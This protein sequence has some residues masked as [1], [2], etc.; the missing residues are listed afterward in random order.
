MI[1]TTTLG[2]F[3][4]CG[5]SWLFA[6]FGFGLC[7]RLGGVVVLLN[8]IVLLGQLGRSGSRRSLGATTAF[9]L[10]GCG[11]LFGSFFLCCFRC[12]GSCPLLGTCLLFGGGKFGWDNVFF[13]LTTRRGLGWYLVDFWSLDAFLVFT[14]LSCL[15]GY[16]R[17]RREPRL[18]RRS[19]HGC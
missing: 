7:I 9:L 19:W 1:T 6:G 10:V 3:R 15:L 13:V 5:A 12:F 4:S 18:G 2:L 16:R 14:V 11:S 17:S 8:L